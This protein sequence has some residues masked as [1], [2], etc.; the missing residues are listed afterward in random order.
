MMKDILLGED[1]DLKCKNGDFAIGDSAGQHQQCLL[2]AEK[3]SYKQ[4]PTVGVGIASFL[5]DDNTSDLLREIRIQFS[6]DGMNVKQ[7]GFNGGKLN[8]DAAYA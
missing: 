1:F 4:Y 5:K 3:G 6:R 2:L 7:L 8:I